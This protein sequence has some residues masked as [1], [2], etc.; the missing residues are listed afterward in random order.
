[1]F[2]DKVDC[3][4][5]RIFF[6][7]RQ[8]LFSDLVTQLGKKMWASPCRV[9][10][11]HSEAI[12]HISQFYHIAS[13]LTRDK[14]WKPHRVLIHFKVEEEEM[15]SLAPRFFNFKMIKNDTK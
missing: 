5:A 12:F 13:E 15:K 8:T 3:R 11:P 10:I 1:M 2:S 7:G 4:V 6:A 9:I 14:F